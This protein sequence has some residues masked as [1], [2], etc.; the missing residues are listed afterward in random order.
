MHNIELG[1]LRTNPRGTGV[2]W[3]TMNINRLAIL[4]GGITIGAAAGVALQFSSVSAARL[5]VHPVRQ[6]RSRSPSRAM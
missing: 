1:S 3:A 6:G 4:V 5:R 2:V